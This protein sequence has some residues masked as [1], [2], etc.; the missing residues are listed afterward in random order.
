MKVAL[1]S[2]YF[3]ETSIPLAKH[4]SE[5][6]IKVDLYSVLPLNLRNSFAIDYSGVPCKAGFDN[7][8]NEIVINEK[9]KEY[10]SSFNY[11]SFFFKNGVKN[12]ANTIYLTY[13]LARKLK[14]ENYDIIHIIGGL[15]HF[16]LIH[17]IF[18][19][20]PRVHTF[21]ETIRENER[22]SIFKRILF[23]M[24]LNKR[25]N[26]ITH[27]ETSKQQ[28]INYNNN[29]K[30]KISLI[31]F[32]LFETYKCFDDESTNSISDSNTIL[33]YGIINEYKGLD[34]L[35]EA[36]AMLQKEIPEAHLIIAGYGDLTRY[37]LS[38]IN[39]LT[40]INRFLSNYEVVNLVKKATFIVC[41]YINA[42]QSGIPKVVY[43]FNKPIIASNVGNFSEDVHHMV[44]GILLPP[45]DSFELYKAM[46]MLL[47]DKHTLDALKK[48]IEQQIADDKYDW[49]LISSK[50]I[51]I[52]KKLYPQF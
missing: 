43:Q 37:N 13:I 23:S 42:S 44:S 30:R 16:I 11:Y 19:R 2:G 40:L 26:I 18:S 12:I 46:I 34:Y 22:P 8:P 51:K 32:G 31:P 14:K 7:S 27:S 20:K 28:L 21:H 33:Y 41:P 39:N 17:L 4:L 52:Y 5:Q 36:F 15:P 24:L 48:G 50:T 45:K 25:V 3:L 6:G 49:R 47:R 38:S 10:M 9:L 1:I 35:I 29:L